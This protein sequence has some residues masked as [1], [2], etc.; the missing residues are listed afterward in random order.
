M[1]NTFTT[2]VNSST[3]LSV[4]VLMMETQGAFSITVG[5][6]SNLPNSTLTYRIV[7]TDTHQN[8]VGVT[9]PLTFTTGQTPDWNLNS[10]LGTFQNGD[11]AMFHS[12]GDFSYIKVDGITPSGSVWNVSAAAGYYT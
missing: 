7:A 5:G 1:L 12:L 6:V 9:G 11:E 4:P 8:V 2:V 3:S 10:Y